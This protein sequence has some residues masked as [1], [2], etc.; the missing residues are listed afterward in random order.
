[1]PGA[2]DG[3]DAIG[4]AYEAFQKGEIEKTGVMVH[5]VVAE[6][7][8]GEPLVVREI[9][10]TKGESKEDLESK[11]HQVCLMSDHATVTD[12]LQIEHEIIVEGAKK[13]LAELDQS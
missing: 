12:T 8:R 5:R 9:P 7:D 4:R 11:I 6:V 13:V 3:A 2:F 1:L 10:M